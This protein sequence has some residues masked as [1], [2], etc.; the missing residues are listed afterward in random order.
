MA[1]TENFGQNKG[2]TI[3]LSTEAILN[4]GQIM[5]EKYKILQMIIYMPLH[6]V[7]IPGMLGN[8]FLY[9]KEVSIGISIQKWWMCEGKF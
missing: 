9:Q 2:Q 5:Q 8:D 1:S 4:M 7:K 6:S 3:K